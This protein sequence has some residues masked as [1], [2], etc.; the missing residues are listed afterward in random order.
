MLCDEPRPA[1]GRGE[2]KRAEHKLRKVKRRTALPFPN[3]DRYRLLKAA[4]EV[5]L[6]THCGVD[7]DDFSRV[8]LDEES[9]RLNRHGAPQA[10]SRQQM[11]D[12][13]DARRRAATA[14]SSTCCR[15]SG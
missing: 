14:S 7:L 5:F 1:F 9:R 8:D 15:T 13:L 11:R 4:T 12:Y 6:M 10:S 3:V 2:R